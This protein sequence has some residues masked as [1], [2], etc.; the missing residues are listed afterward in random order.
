MASSEGGEG[1]GV[2]K[3]IEKYALLHFACHGWLDDHDSLRSCLV[4]ASERK[5]AGIADCWKR[6]KS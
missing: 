3:L 2:R 6:G 1:S 4:L 5:A